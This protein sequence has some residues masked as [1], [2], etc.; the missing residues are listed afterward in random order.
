M[1]LWGAETTPK[2]IDGKVKLAGESVATGPGDTFTVRGA[3]TL[4]VPELPVRIKLYCPGLTAPLAFSVRVV[5]PVVGL[6]EKEAV[7]PVGRREAARVTFP[8]NPYWGSTWM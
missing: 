6:G 7:M 2:T 8:V 1:A 4:R 3:D 5:F